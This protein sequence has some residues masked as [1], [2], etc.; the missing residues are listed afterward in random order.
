[1]VQALLQYELKRYRQ[2]NRTHQYQRYYHH[3]IRYVCA[4]QSLW[5][6]APQEL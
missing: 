4:F 2:L 5:A 6:S 1:M 3:T